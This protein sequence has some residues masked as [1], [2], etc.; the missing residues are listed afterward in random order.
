MYIV[1]SVICLIGLSNGEVILRGPPRVETN[2]KFSSSYIPAAMQIIAHD[3]ELMKYVIKPVQG[4]STTT[5]TT[6]RP[7]PSHKPGIFAPENPVGSTSL[8]SKDLYDEYVNRQ[9]QPSGPNYFDR[10]DTL[11]NIYT[12]Q[13]RTFSQSEDIPTDIDNYLGKGFGDVIRLANR[14]DDDKPNSIEDYQVL[15]FSRDFEDPDSH[16]RYELLRQKK[17]PPTKAYVSLLALYDLLNK[18]SKR[19][20][21]NKF[22]GYQQDVLKDLIDFSSSTAS[23]QLLSV[24]KKVVEKNEIKKADVVMKMKTLI[25]DLEEENSYINL[26]LKDIPPLVFAP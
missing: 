11:M 26:A 9:R 2:P 17:V 1:L 8:S 23:Y 14:I 15:E 18:E 12:Q 13:G 6:I 4:T 25:T 7:T 19:L 5:S 21:L 16:F 22:A 20:M 3:T 24:L 10:Y